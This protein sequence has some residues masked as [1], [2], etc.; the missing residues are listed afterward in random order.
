[1]HRIPQSDIFRVSDPSAAGEV[2]RAAVALAASLG[3][4]DTD[5]GNVAIVAAEITKNVVIHAR[6]GEVLLRAARCDEVDAVE[7]LALDKGPG[8]AD[9]SRCM[10]D[11]YSTAG[12]AGIGL[13]AISRLS[14]LFDVYSVPGG[15]TAV[16]A[17]VRP[18]ALAPAG[19]GRAFDWG[20]V[21]LAKS[22]EQVC[23]DACAIARAGEGTAFVVA[24]GLGHGPMAHQAA[25]E[26]VRVFGD[27]VETDLV[28]LMGLMDAALRPTRG[29]AVSVVCWDPRAGEARFVG[30]G[31]VS[32]TMVANGATR[33]MAAHNG[34]VG[35]SMRKV[36]PFSYPWPADGILVMCSDGLGTQWQIA[37]YPGLSQRH[38]ALLAGVLY[39]DFNRGR[40]DVTV[41][42]ARAARGAA[43]EAA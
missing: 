13:G 8:M 37:K 34:T 5:Q 25:A 10:R 9:V 36:Q 33:S 19:N 14:S 18:R 15:G 11:G 29:A 7:L 39:R 21:Q 32:A 16:L 6:A 2:R 31:N 26:A 28:R 38:P 24:D 4:D 1:M 22:G 20:V 43:G 23:G 17:R 42:A 12:T 3:F 35:H 40:D 30:V 41:L 27:N